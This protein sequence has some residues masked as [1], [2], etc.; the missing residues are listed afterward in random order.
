MYICHAGHARWS[1]HS[2]SHM[3]VQQQVSTSQVTAFNSQVPSGLVFS[4][5]AQGLGAILCD[6]WHRKEHEALAHRVARARAMREGFAE[7]LVA[8]AGHAADVRASKESAES[9]LTTAR[10]QFEGTRSDWKRKLTDRR[11]KVGRR[12]PAACPAA[13]ASVQQPHVHWQSMHG[14]LTAACW[15][16]MRPAALAWLQLHL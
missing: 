7:D 11:K 12:L 5:A 9:A 6:G 15:D 10:T 2:S 13:V 8:M 4:S 16:S 3:L 1:A 14:P